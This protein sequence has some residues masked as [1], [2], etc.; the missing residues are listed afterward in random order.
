MTL[1]LALMMFHLWPGDHSHEFITASSVFWFHAMFSAARLNP[2]LRMSRIELCTMRLRRAI[3][4][5][6]SWAYR[7]SFTSSESGLSDHHDFARAALC[8]ATSFF[9]SYIALA[10]HFGASYLVCEASHVGPPLAV[11][12]RVAEPPVAIPWRPA[13]RQQIVGVQLKLGAAGP[14]GVTHRHDVVH[15]DVAS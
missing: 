10:P 15:L 11:V 9:M 3:V 2:S 12:A 13:E 6:H 4:V 1:L 5:A 7:M 8:S 14:L